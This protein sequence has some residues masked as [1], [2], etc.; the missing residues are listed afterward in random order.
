MPILFYFI[1]YTYCLLIMLIAITVFTQISIVRWNIH[2]LIKRITYLSSKSPILPALECWPHTQERL[3]VRVY[4]VSMCFTYSPK[5]VILSLYGDHLTHFN[6]KRGVILDIFEL[7]TE[8]HHADA[9][10]FLAFIMILE[11]PRCNPPYKRKQ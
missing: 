2:V 10:F 3:W 6:F 1:A 7:H 11:Q 4:P 8:M 5:R 9:D